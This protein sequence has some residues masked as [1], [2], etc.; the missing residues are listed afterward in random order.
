LGRQLDDE[1]PGL[2]ERSA[3]GVAERLVANVGEIADPEQTRPLPGQRTYVLWETPRGVGF[4]TGDDSSRLE[5]W[6]ALVLAPLLAGNGLLLAPAASHREATLRLVEALYE[7]GVP[8][9]VLEVS[10]Y[11]PEAAVELAYLPINFAALDVAES[12]ER[13]FA[14]EL[15]RSPDSQRWLKARISVADG[16]GPEEPGFLRR[17]ALPKTVSIRTLNHGAALEE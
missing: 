15:G 4:A 10:Q 2:I 6:L 14:E 17:F 1:A 9:D 7:A 16:P 3:L 12:L 8:R 5:D 13:R 11:G